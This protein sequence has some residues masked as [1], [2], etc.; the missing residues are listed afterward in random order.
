MSASTCFGCIHVPTQMPATTGLQPQTANL[1]PI[2]QDAVN[3]VCFASY[4][5]HVPE[6]I[7][8]DMCFARAL[9]NMSISS[10]I[11]FV[12]IAL[13]G[14]KLHYDWAPYGVWWA[15]STLHVILSPST[16][17]LPISVTLDILL[18]RE[19][20]LQFDG[21]VTPFTPS[22]LTYHSPIVQLPDQPDQVGHDGRRSTGEAPGDVVH[23][24]RGD[25]HAYVSVDPSHTRLSLA[26]WS[27]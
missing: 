10:Q 11:G 3:D 13:G 14:T 18:R 19:S 25:G 4:G 20:G 23:R 1:R 6:S 21:K 27:H 15:K 8:P 7:G 9:I 26:H 5:V 2:S 16:L 24:G 22:S 12:P 17:P